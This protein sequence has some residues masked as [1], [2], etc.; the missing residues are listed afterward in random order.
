M[1]GLDETKK[2]PAFFCK[3]TLPSIVFLTQMTEIV[4]ELPILPNF[5]ITSIELLFM[6]VNGKKS[7]SSN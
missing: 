4:T 6:S 1:L 3:F 2:H 5:P 7:K